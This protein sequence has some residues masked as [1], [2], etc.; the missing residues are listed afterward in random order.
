[1]NITDDIYNDLS[2]RIDAGEFLS[3]RTSSAGSLPSLPKAVTEEERYRKECDRIV[4]LYRQMVEFYQQKENTA[5]A[6]EKVISM[7][8]AADAMRADIDRKMAEEYNEYRILSGETV[9]KLREDLD[10]TKKISSNALNRCDQL[11]QMVDMYKEKLDASKKKCA[12]L[13]NLLRD[14]DE[15]LAY[16]E[17]GKAFILM[18]DGMPAGTLGMTDSNQL[19][20]DIQAKNAEIEQLTISLEKEKKERKESVSLLAASMVDT[21][22]SYM[23]DLDRVQKSEVLVGE[24]LMK[25]MISVCRHQIDQQ[26]EDKLRLKISYISDNRE[27]AEREEK[28]R[29]KA[30]KE[31]VKQM[32][33][34][35]VDAMTQNADAMKEVASKPTTEIRQMN[36]CEGRYFENTSAADV[37]SIPDLGEVR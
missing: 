1:M 6:A 25:A 28:A 16:Y 18:E 2:K 10:E 36:M 20:D 33:Q 11:E 27:R 3:V 23:S 14:K 21:G 5:M 12:H 9:K 35:K 29:L 19:A 32:E 31:E 17:N 8:D 22:V 7:A 13:R 24:R 15:A 4:N 26:M 37:A 34:K 30:E